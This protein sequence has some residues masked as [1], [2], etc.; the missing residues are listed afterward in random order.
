[1]VLCSPKD[2]NLSLKEK[3]NIYIYDPMLRIWNV[4]NKKR[5]RK[6]FSLP[7]NP[8]KE[9]AVPFVWGKEEGGLNFMFPREL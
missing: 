7:A 9:W 2:H 6:K 5:S 3:G 8:K 1:M 4:R